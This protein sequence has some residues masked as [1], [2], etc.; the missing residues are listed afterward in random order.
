MYKAGGKNSV[1]RR[2]KSLAA[3]VLFGTA[4]IMTTFL[5]PNVAMAAE[6]EVLPIVAYDFED[7]IGEKAEAIVQGG[8]A[9]EGEVNEALAVEYKMDGLVN[10]Q[11]FDASGHGNHGTLYHPETV[12]FVNDNGRNVI[13]IQD[14]ASYISIPIGIMDSLTDKE[15]FTI[16]ITY[17]RSAKA[18]GNSWLFGFGSIPK[19]TGTNYLFYC[20]YFSFGNGEVRAGIKDATTEKLFTTGV[21]N[22]NDTYYTVDMV[23]KDG[24]I[25]LFIDGIK[26]GGQLDSGFSIVEDV[27]NQG[28]ADGILG[29]IGKSCWAQDTNFVGRIDSFRIYDKAMNEEEV[30]NSNPEYLE[31]LRNKLEEGVQ[32]AELL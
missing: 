15:Q 12:E 14:P 30:Q 7:G 22:Q 16:E 8:D 2:A 21:R 25:T 1:K 20:P 28:T 31:N 29:F 4:T 27:V 19:A 24:V 26:I 9:Y 10:D 5:A 18:G 13:D 3:A 23:V 11:L 17:S 32:E 6:E